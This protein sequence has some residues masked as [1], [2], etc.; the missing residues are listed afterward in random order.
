MRN[1]PSGT[2]ELSP[3]LCTMLAFPMEISC[4]THKNAVAC[5]IS[6]AH[7]H[8]VIYSCLQVH[9]PTLMFPDWSRNSRRSTRHC[10][11]HFYSAVLH[12]WFIDVGLLSELQLLCSMGAV[13]IYHE[14]QPFLVHGHHEIQNIIWAMNVSFGEG[15]KPTHIELWFSAI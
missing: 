13:E 15:R 2:G 7:S 9:L 8:P 12:A 5:I 3:G 6:V 11:T 1:V 4:L 10:V 14:I